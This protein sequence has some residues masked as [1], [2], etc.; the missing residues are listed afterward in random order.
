MFRAVT[1]RF[2]CLPVLILVL[3]AATAGAA[4]MPQ[5]FLTYAGRVQALLMQG[6]AKLDGA[7]E[8]WSGRVRLWVDETG[9]VTRVTLGKATGPAMDAVALQKVLAQTRLPPPPSG[10]PMPIILRVTAKTPATPAPS[11]AL[12]AYLREVERT[13][14]AGLRGM[15][16]IPVVV[17]GTARLWLDDKGRVTKAE[18]TGLTGMTLN[19]GDVRAMLAR[20]QFPAP[21]DGTPMP[22]STHVKMEPKR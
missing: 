19:D 8:G 4:E 15:P 6:V 20:L 21:P 1:M 22:V 12:T 17:D 9:L 11:P 2:A 10:L 14:L 16:D 13:V 5:S 3:L 18:L 7:P